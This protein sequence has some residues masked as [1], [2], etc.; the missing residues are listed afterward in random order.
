MFA[1]DGFGFGMW[2]A[3]LP[4]F[5]SALGLSDG[6]L[7]VPLFGM[8]AGSLFAMPVAGLSSRPKHSEFGSNACSRM[9]SVLSNTYHYGEIFDHENEFPVRPGGD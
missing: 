1:V 3:Q 5:K 4:A 7:S 9:R 2:A 6:R 8:V